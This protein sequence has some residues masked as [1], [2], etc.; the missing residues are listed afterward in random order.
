LLEWGTGEEGLLVL[1]VLLWSGLCA[2]SVAAATAADSN[3]APPD[4]ELRSSESGLAPLGVDAGSLAYYSTTEPDVSWGYPKD[5]SV[6]FQCFVDDLPA[7]CSESYYR[8]CCPRIVPKRLRRRAP[9]PRRETLWAPFTLAQR[10]CQPGPLPPPYVP[11]GKTL[12]YGPFTGWVPIPTGIGDG[13]HTIKVVATDED[14]SDPDPPMVTSVIDRTRPSTPRILAAPAK[15]GRDQTPRFKFTATDDRYIRDEYNQPISAQ[16]KRLE[17]AG[18]PIFNGTPLG[19]YLEWRGPFC[20][21]P[22]RCTEVVWPAYTV[23]GKGGTT[24]GHRQHLL[25]GLYEFSL[26]AKDIVGNKSETARY[27][28][29]VLSR[30]A[31]P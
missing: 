5:S 24:Y 14:G 21:T 11:P 28:F 2:A 1:G 15:A 18:A 27:R 17:P 23:E 7:T 29:R 26:R 4:L 31:S 16:L 13:I 19:H 8:E 25:P 30:A 9:C 10:R 20:P 6:S 3:S 12:G 22:R